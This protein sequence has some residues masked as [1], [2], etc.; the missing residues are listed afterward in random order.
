VSTPAAS[1]PQAMTAYEVSHW[2]EAGA[3]VAGSGHV[4]VVAS[5]PARSTVTARRPACTGR[6]ARKL[7]GISAPI[8]A[9]AQSTGCRVPGRP[10]SSA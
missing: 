8:D 9:V 6:D 7:V 10:R 5:N 1:R 3:R 2:S 4:P